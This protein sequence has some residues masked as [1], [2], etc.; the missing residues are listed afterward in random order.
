MNK[1][2]YL[3]H[4]LVISSPTLMMHGHMTLKY[5][6]HT[7]FAINLNNRAYKTISKS[8]TT[9]RL[10]QSTLM[11]DDHHTRVLVT[12]FLLFLRVIFNDALNFGDNIGLL[13]DG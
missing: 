10:P 13:T 1:H 12:L 4:P 6:V 2:L 7:L 5:A 9:F 8:T 11:Y 3:C